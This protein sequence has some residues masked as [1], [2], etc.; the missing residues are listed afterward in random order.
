MKGSRN[1]LRAF[2]SQLSGQGVTYTPQYI[3]QEEFDAII[4]S[5]LET[6]SI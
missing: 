6:G 5:P 4:D 2:I 1:H 3:T